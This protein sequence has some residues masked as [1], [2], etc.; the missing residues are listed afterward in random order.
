M[1]AALLGE[2]LETIE[3]ELPAGPLSP[4]EGAALQQ[5]R[6]AGEMKE[7]A[8]D[9]AVHHGGSRAPWTVL[10]E[11]GGKVEPLCGNRTVKVVPVVRAAEALSELEGLAD[12]LQT[13]GVEGL[14]EERDFV[15]EAL[16]RMGVSR[17]VGFS[18]VPW[19]PP[20]WHHDGEGPLRTLVRWT[21]AE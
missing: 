21:D 16:A 4:E 3:H 13:V 18:Q 20:W 5:L 7:A 6:G 11:P 8:G 19:P 1:W 15:V 2:A 12:H 9:G 10:F 14:G 17:V